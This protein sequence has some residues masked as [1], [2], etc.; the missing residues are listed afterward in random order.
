M[1]QQHQLEEEIAKAKE[2]K[3]RKKK[4]EEKEKSPINAQN[5]AKK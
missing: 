5:E 2:A 3:E 4:R 1:K